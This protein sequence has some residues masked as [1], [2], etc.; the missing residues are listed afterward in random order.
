VLRPSIECYG[1]CAQ[2]WASI[3]PICSQADIRPC[4][5]V[6]TALNNNASTVL[7]KRSPFRSCSQQPRPL[8][9][10]NIIGQATVIDGDTIEIR[11]PADSTLGNDAPES[12]Q[13]SR[14]SDSQLFLSGS[15]AANCLADHIIITCSPMATDRYRR[16]VAVCLAGC[17]D[18]GHWASP[19]RGYQIHFARER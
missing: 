19:P 1:M 9:C 18:L 7:I 5:Q 8:R 10:Q 3:N 12:E 17:F 16:V 2:R 15:V 11:T 13:F 6:Q 14:G 4:E